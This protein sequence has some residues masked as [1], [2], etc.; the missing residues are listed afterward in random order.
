MTERGLVA[1]TGFTVESGEELWRP[2]PVWGSGI[3]NVSNMMLESLD[4]CAT[5]KG[6]MPGCKSGGVQTPPRGLIHGP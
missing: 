6:N 3:A 5:I 1:L 2:P 4:F